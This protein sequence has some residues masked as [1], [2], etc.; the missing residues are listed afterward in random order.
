VS[1]ARR[2][3]A[4]SDRARASNWPR[5]RPSLRN[6]ATRKVCRLRRCVI[7]HR[8]LGDASRGNLARHRSEMRSRIVRPPNFDSYPARYCS[9]ELNVAPARNSSDIV[10]SYRRR[11]N[12]RGEQIS[13]GILCYR[14]IRLSLSP[15]LSL[16]LSLC[17]SLSLSPPAQL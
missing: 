4:G 14:D 11:R 8:V 6:A 7:T 5:R 12:L 3:E 13:R 9:R 2:F 10:R 16:Y 1:P 17:L 15:S